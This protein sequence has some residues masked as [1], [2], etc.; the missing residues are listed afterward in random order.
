MFVVVIGG[1]VAV[2][3]DVVL[4]QDEKFR[5]S[6]HLVKIGDD[7]ILV[8]LGEELRKSCHFVKIEGTCAK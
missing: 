3:I 1:G 4:P 8:P 7:S 2:V 5:R 6:C